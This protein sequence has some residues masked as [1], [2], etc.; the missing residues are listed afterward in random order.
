MSKHKVAYALSAVSLSLGL[1]A[2]ASFQAWATPSGDL[3]LCSP[4]IDES[5]LPVGLVLEN[6]ESRCRGRCQ[7]SDFR[8]QSFL[9]NILL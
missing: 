6:D 9:P 8:N 3:D 2:M 4:T 1:G 5:I 7:V